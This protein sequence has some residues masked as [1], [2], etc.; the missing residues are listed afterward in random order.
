M[1]ISIMSRR[2]IFIFTHM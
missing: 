1:I 2:N